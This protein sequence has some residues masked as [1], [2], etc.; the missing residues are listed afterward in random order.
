[1]E[2]QRQGRG[3]PAR[4]GRAPALASDRRCRGCGGGKWGAR[5]RD[6]QGSD[7]GPGHLAAFGWRPIGKSTCLC[8]SKCT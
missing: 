7:T 8:N 1:M 4:F 5:R 2:G 6:G 3:D